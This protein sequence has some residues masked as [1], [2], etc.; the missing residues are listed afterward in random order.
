M[1]SA[2]WILVQTV[3]RDIL[4]CDHNIDGLSIHY[5]MLNSYDDVLYAYG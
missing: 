2:S 1:Q 5:T 4:M 3:Y